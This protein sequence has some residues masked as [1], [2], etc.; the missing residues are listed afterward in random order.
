MGL[1]PE[2]D[3]VLLLRAD[4]GFGGTVNFI[5]AA[6]GADKPR[7]QLALAGRHGNAAA[8]RGSSGDIFHFQLAAGG[9]LPRWT[10]L[11]HLEPAGAS[12][13]DQWALWLCG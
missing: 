9:R 6:L 1:L 7:F 4:V 5:L 11:T 3:T 10:E 8:T 12:R 2:K 13:R